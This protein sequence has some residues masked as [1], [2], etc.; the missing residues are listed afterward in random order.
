[1]EK[2]DFESVMDRRPYTACK[3]LDVP[4]GI[5]PMTIADMEFASPPEVLEALH[6]RDN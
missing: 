3:W 1:M 2:Y 4:E 5:L 6:S